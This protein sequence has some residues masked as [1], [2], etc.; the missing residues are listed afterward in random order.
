MAS[1]LLNPGL[2]EMWRTNSIMSGRARSYGTGPVVAPLSIKTVKSGTATWLVGKKEFVVS[3]D[4]F[5]VVNEGQEYE[6]LIGSATPVETLC[7]FFAPGYFEE[8]WSAHRDTLALEPTPSGPLELPNRLD[9]TPVLLKRL[10]AH[11]PSDIGEDTFVDLAESM[12]DLWTGF[13]EEPLRL[14]SSRESTRTELMKRL[15]IVRDLILSS[16]D[17][18]LMLE[19]MASEAG[20]SK[21]HLHRLFRSAFG[22]T[23]HGYLTE[24]RLARAERLL[25]DTELDLTQICLSLGFSSESS[26][27]RLYRQ[28]RGRSPGHARRLARSDNQLSR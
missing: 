25:R 18:P 16:L 5:L 1:P 20:L 6:L 28:R 8:A 22:T 21:F 2:A 24:A 23:P 9:L 26:F 11:D 7:F 4:C 14:E 27:C 10:A 17:R 13:R 19:T 3:P 15:D 12:I